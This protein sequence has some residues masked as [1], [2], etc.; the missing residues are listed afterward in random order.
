MDNEDTDGLLSRA[1]RY[2]DMAFSVRDDRVL[3]NIIRI[4]AEELEERAKD[5]GLPSKADVTFG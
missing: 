4:A 1:Q 2:R 5:I 3:A